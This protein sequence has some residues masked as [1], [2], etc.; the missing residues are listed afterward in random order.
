MKNAPPAYRMTGMIH[1]ISPLIIDSYL[2][3]RRILSGCKRLKMEVVRR[4]LNGYKCLIENNS[5]DNHRF[6]KII[7]VAT[8]GE[9]RK[10]TSCMSP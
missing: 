2:G 3:F 7:S 4:V 1:L 8:M 6:I 5:T 10:L 9:L